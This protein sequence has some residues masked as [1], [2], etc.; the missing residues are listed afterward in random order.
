MLAARLTPDAQEAITPGDA[1]AGLIRN[2][3]GLANRPRSLPPQF[4]TNTPRDRLCRRGVRAERFHRLKRGRT[5]E[6]VQ[7]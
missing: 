5:L 4:C 7:A 2:G 6:A 3:L 1:V